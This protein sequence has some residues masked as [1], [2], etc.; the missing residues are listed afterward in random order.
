MEATLSSLFPNAVEGYIFLAVLLLWM[1]FTFFIER[2]II[3]WDKRGDVKARRDRGSFLLIYIGVFLSL[4]VAFA[5]GAE[6]IAVLPDW[7]FYVGILMMLLGIV[8][9]EWAVITLR[10]FFSFSVR[11]LQD[12]KVVDTGPYRLVRHPAYAG[13]ILTMV[14]IGVALLTWA[15]AL[16]ILLFCVV[17]YGYRMRVEEKAMVNELGDDYSEYMRRTKRLI[18]FI[19]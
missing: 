2:A 9:R 6:Q 15:A 5:F 14:G 10:R 1:A 16:L 18:P 4:G 17:V 11:V 8:V 3:G 12:H 19:L 13:S 7:F